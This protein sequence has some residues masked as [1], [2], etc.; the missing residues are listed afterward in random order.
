MNPSRL[1]LL[2][3]FTLWL[4]CQGNVN[5]EESSPLEHL[6]LS[7]TELRQAVVHSP[8][9]AIEPTLQKVS[10]TLELVYC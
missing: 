1:F 10:K 4:G 5:R 2:L 9:D 3:S 6:N 8:S 7:D